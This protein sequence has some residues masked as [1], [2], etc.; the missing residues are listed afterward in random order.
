MHVSRSRIYF[1]FELRSVRSSLFW[2]FTSVKNLCFFGSVKTGSWMIAFFFLKKIL[3][4]ETILWSNRND[5]LN[6]STC[7]GIKQDVLELRG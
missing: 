2:L 5:S 1:H 4:C 6:P 7:L 3:P